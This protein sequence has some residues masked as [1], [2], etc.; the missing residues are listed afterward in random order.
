MSAAN[1][2]V[3][4]VP[5]P[6]RQ[7][8]PADTSLSSNVANV[9]EWAGRAQARVGQF[10]RDAYDTSREGSVSFA[11]TVRD[12]SVRMKQENPMAL[13]GGIAGTAFALGV[14]ARVWR[15]RR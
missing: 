13:I 4:I 5:D 11:R 12:R 15:S 14:A 2:N 7:L 9:A 8:P 6:G 3:P 1:P 10:F